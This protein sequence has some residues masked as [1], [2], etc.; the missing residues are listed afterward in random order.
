MKKK[1]FDEIL[2]NT[3]PTYPVTNK[4]ST[5]SLITCLHY[6]KALVVGWCCHV[7]V[8]HSQVLHLIKNQM[9][10]YWTDTLFKSNGDKFIERT[11]QLSETDCLCSS[12]KIYI[13]C[14]L[15]LTLKKERFYIGYYEVNELSANVNYTFVFGW[16]GLTFCFWHFWLIV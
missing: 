5:Q 9:I 1:H 6:L 7:A 15:R 11:R 13:A 3:Q 14:F 16:W 10:Y 4:R 12:M 2:I 8:W